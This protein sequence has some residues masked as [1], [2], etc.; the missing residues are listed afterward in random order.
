MSLLRIPDRQDLEETNLG[1]HVA[2]ARHRYDALEER[3]IR[4][5]T[6][7][8]KINE[9]FKSNRKFLLALVGTAAAGLAS[10]IVPILMYFLNKQIQ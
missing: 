2:L 6:D 9:Q 3:V 4:N 5:E 1:T 8:E 7:I 10:V